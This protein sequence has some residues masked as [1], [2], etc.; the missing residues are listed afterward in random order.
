MTVYKQLCI[1]CG[2]IQPDN[3]DKHFTEIILK[4]VSMCQVPLIN[5]VH[6]PYRKLWTKCFSLSYGPS[7]KHAG[8]KKRG[9]K[10]SMHGTDQANEINEMFIIW[11]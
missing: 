8:H 11:L 6:G 4:A 2:Q 5:R 9:K 7:V 10:G 3:A 1:K